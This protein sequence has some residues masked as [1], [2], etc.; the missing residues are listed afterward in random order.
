MKSSIDDY[1]QMERSQFITV[2]VNV[3]CCFVFATQ[4]RTL[5]NMMSDRIIAYPKQCAL[6]SRPRI[7]INTIWELL[8]KKEKA[9]RLQR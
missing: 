1:V 3:L 7:G 9:A 4:R 6:L 5:E 8:I 2:E